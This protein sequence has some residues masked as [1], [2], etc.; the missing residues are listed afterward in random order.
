M[1]L[2]LYRFSTYNGAV[3]QRPLARNGGVLVGV[4]AAINFWW[5]IADVLLIVVVAPVCLYF[6]NKVL[7][8]VKEIYAYGDDILEH[9]V[10]ITAQLDAVPKLVRTREL[11]GQAKQGAGRYAAGLQRLL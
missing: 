1:G 4:V 2:P 9:G 6:L 10:G 8:P 7:R 3:V 5:L 11:T